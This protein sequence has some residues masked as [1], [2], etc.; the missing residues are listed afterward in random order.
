V[1]SLVTLLPQVTNCA[2]EQFVCVLLLLLQVLVRSVGPLWTSSTPSSWVRATT[3]Q[4]QQQQQQQALR[5]A[6]LLLLMVM[7]SAPVTQGMG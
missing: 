2:G 3:S 5:K 7:R 1:L 4:Q 6:V